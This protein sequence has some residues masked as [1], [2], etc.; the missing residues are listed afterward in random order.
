[1]VCANPI[2]VICPVTPIVTEPITKMVVAH[3]VD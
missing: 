2:M 3:T 1:M